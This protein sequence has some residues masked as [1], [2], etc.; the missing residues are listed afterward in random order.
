M[1]TIATSAHWGLH[2]CIYQLDLLEPSFQTPL[3]FQLI[4]IQVELVHLAVGPIYHL[5]LP[6][7]LAGKMKAKEAVISEVPW[8]AKGLRMRVGIVPGDVQTMALALR[9]SCY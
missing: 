2:L 4:E 3:F 5:P 1:N 7:F 8:W 6:C 9:S